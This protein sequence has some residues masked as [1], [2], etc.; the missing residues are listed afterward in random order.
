LKEKPETIL[1]LGK[2]GQVGWEL[3]RALAPLSPLV[4]LGRDTENGL[5][6][7]LANPEGLQATIQTLRPSV[8]VNAAAYTAV[9]AAEQNPELA[10]R[11]N[12]TAPG[13]LAEA[14][15]AV[16]ALLVHYSTD[17]VFNGEGDLPWQ[18]HHSTHPL[19]TYGESK[20]AGE[21]AIQQAG[22]QHMI[23]RTSWV[24]ARHGRNFVNTMANL[25][26]QKPSLNIV[27][28]QIGAP[29][30]A[31]LI[32][33]ITAHCLRA[34]RPGSVD[35]GVYH[36]AAS[37]DTSWCDYARYIAE[38]LQALGAPVTAPPQSI[39]PI[40][41]EHYPTPAKRPLNSRL[42]TQKLQTRYGL[43]LPH[44]KLGVKRALMDARMDALKD[45]AKHPIC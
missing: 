40:A 19:N 42:N 25:I 30:S 8:I 33:D 3:Q 41:S 11:I 21:H 37:G 39:L 20:L 2:N 15:K 5:C 28:D 31:E 43:T 23:F 16:G 36:L 7:D 9:D 4:A 32:A 18:E 14:A 35:N 45:K 10:H 13:V 26:Q 6:G 1:L 34:R 44:W 27:G 38:T 17:Y 24:Y 12:A 22:G 29:T